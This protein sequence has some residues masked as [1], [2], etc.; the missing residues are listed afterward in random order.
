MEEANAH[1]T[2]SAWQRIILVGDAYELWVEVPFLALHATNC[3]FRS[4]YPPSLAVAGAQAQ[5]GADDGDYN[6]GSANVVTGYHQRY[7]HHR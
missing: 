1:W 2:G 6:V 3:P 4:V 5:T 7:R